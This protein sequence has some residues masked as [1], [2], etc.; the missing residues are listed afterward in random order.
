MLMQAAD[1]ITEPNRLQ[2]Y[3][4]VMVALAEADLLAEL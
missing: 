4:H 2:E 3:R 1:C